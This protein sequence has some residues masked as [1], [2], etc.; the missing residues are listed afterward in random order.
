M[1]NNITRQDAKDL[2]DQFK[3]FK[4]DTPVNTLEVENK[5]DCLYLTTKW[6]IGENKVASQYVSEDDVVSWIHRNYE[7][8]ET[9]N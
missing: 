6:K 9:S 7:Q 5:N 8:I 1:K 4:L 3:L 2:L